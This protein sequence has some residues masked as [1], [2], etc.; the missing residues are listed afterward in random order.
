MIAKTLGL[1]DISD[2]IPWRSAFPEFVE[3]H[4]PSV[5]LRGARKK[6][7]PTQKE[8]ARRLAKVLNVSYK[9]FL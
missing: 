6:E 2:S 3:E 1:A 8:L 7:G 4:I 5:A 9:V